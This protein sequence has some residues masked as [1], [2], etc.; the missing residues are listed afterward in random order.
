MWC[1]PWSLRRRKTP[2]VINAAEREP[3]DKRT[4]V[5]CFAVG[6]A[7]GGPL[8]VPCGHVFCPPCVAKRC[9]LGL[10]DRTLVPAHCCGLEFPIE[11]VEKTL[12]SSGFKTYKR[13]LSER[14]WKSTRL[15]SDVE[16][17]AMVKGAGGMQCPR[18]GVGVVKESGC[19]HM[20]C[21]CGCAFNYVPRA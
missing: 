11:Y 16:Y 15:R 7:P 19:Q 3:S 14:E 13:F 12:G 2:D 4:C 17:A 1:S 8:A 21:L 18:C 6:C 9:A 20:K 5:S 10:A